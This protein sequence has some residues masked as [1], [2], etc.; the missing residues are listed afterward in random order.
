M[1]YRVEITAEAERELHSILSWLLSKHAGDD[2]LRWFEALEGAL[3][4]LRE[5]PK[6]CSVAPESR[7]LPFEVRQLVYGNKPHV[8]RILFTMRI[9][10]Y[11]FFMYDMDDD[12]QL[13]HE[14]RQVSWGSS[15]SGANA[16]LVP[17][18]SRK[19]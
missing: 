6:R 7:L 8:Y 5:F 14:K 18:R 16:W 4:S 9:R 15:S 17:R 1:A 12:S 13:C 11:T 2:G 10:G 3:A 19:C